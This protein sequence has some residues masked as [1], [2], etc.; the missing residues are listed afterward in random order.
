MRDDESASCLLSARRGPLLNSSE[1]H[2]AP[3]AFETKPAHTPM[4]ASSARKTRCCVTM[5]IHVRS[6]HI[7]HRVHASSA[8][9]TMFASLN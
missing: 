4:D 2:L 9:F 5:L 6:L 3:Y 1:W 8:S 7:V